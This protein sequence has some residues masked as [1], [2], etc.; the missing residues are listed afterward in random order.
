MTRKPDEIWDALTE[1]FGNV[2]TQ[3]E[4][5]RRNRAVKLLRE[6]EATPEEIRTT[7]E[8]CK[9][10]FTSFTEMALCSWLSRALHE[11]EKSGQRETFL[12][13]LERKTP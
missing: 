7:Y 9:A 4:R 13:L 6:A 1:H 10:R 3:P 5:D 8:Y 11:S 2:R 12:R